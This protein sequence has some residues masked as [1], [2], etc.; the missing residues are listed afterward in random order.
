M[1]PIVIEMYNNNPLI[2]YS[3]Y[4]HTQVEVIRALGNEIISILDNTININE[5]GTHVVGGPE[6]MQAHGKFWL[7]I[8]GSY[9]IV[10]TASQEEGCFTDH[11]YKKLKTF[12]RKIAKLRIPFAKQEYA[13]GGS[14]PIPI[15][16]EA[17]IAGIDYAT[18]D[19]IYA[20]KG[21]RYKPRELIFDFNEL[22]SGISI[23]DILQCH[24]H[25]HRKPK[26]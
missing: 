24:G 14:S 5:G 18:R 1:N 26:S 2:A 15:K 4:T 19:I 3:V 9:E 22:I 7:W 10:R 13:D 11:V 12:K 23:A 17:S 21:N 8:L 16:N 20:V 25:Q 6:I